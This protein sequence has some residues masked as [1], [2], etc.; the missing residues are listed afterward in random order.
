MHGRG[1]EEQALR[2]LL[3]GARDGDGGALVLA[4]EPGMGRTA[5]LGRAAGL[6][7]DGFL[8][9]RVSGVAA[10]SRLPYAGLH[11][12]LRPIAADAAA[13]LPEPQ[14]RSLSPVLRPE[15]SATADGGETAAPGAA[16]G[17]G[18]ASPEPA[19]IPPASGAAQGGGL[20]LPAAVLALLAAVAAERP[21]LACVD[22]MHLLDPASREVLAF[23]ARRVAGERVALVFTTRTGECAPGWAAGLPVVT[24]RGLDG[25]AVRELADDLAPGEITD[26]LLAA[27]NQ[28]A[29]GNPSALTELIGS[30][31][32][33][34]L[35]G[36]A[37][38]PETLPRNG[39]LWREHASRLAALPAETV[40]LLLLVAADPEIDVPAL[41]AAAR[42]RCALAVLEPAERAGILHATG[43]RYAFRDP[44]LR[45][46]AYHGASL[47]QRRTAHRRL[48]TLIEPGDDRP[49]ARLR[50]A[51]HRAWA[52]DAAPDELAD[53]LASAARDDRTPGGH[54]E[55]YQ[56]L[57]RAAELTGRHR[58]EKA[59]R[60]A[61][62]ARHAWVAARRWPARCWPACTAWRR[63]RTRCAPASASC[64]AA[65]S[66]SAA[67]PA[68]P[69]RSCW[70][71][72]RG[73]WRATAS[74]ACGPWCARRT[75]ATVRATT[76]SSSPSPGRRRHYAART[77]R[78]P[79]S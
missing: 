10:E 27:L 73:C 52:M 54:P 44:A 47:L 16:Q 69:G 29:R 43:D 36:V 57:E 65:W 77:S 33:D 14:F 55:T 72:R 51:W 28:I 17:G 59:E 48:A 75:P 71:R 38:P 68:A 2:R 24:L 7:G 13:L 1:A 74:W 58:P 6:A 11:A 25:M 70:P 53:D 64:A 4:G 15:P 56:A 40:R 5:L 60:L 42:P 3:D 22:D 23:T 21:V 45:S 66:S 39:R 37:A 20:P 34:Q 30:L 63:R 41:L 18:P 26:E 35:S 19:P 79:R 9:L 61:A 31:T 46:V 62:A 12:L 78:C 67:R 49:G 50:R 32:R 8:V 76:A